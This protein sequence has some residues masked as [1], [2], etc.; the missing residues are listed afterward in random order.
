MKLALDPMEVTNHVID[1]R[2]HF[3]LDQ[4]GQEPSTKFIVDCLMEEY[5]EWGI[6]NE[7]WDEL[8]ALIDLLTF[9]CGFLAAKEHYK[10]EHIAD[11]FMHMDHTHW[12]NAGKNSINHFLFRHLE[13]ICE[14]ENALDELIPGIFG[15]NN[16]L[17]QKIPRLIENFEQ[18]GHSIC[19]IQL[20][21]VIYAIIHDRDF[22]LIFKD[23]FLEVHNANMKKEVGA[24]DKRGGFKADLIKP[25][26]WQPPNLRKFFPPS[27]D[28]TIE[29]T[30]A[31]VLK[32]RG[33]RYGEF[34]DNARITTSIMAIMESGATW[35]KQPSTNKEALRMIAHKIARVVS[36]DPF[37]EDN[38]VD[39]A[40]YAE[41]ARKEIVK[42]GRKSQI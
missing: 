11:L 41:L 34:I 29:D 30:V 33:S 23:A 31:S 42:C 16:S 27:L 12:K 36:G 26:G 32:D 35:L 10:Q 40:G 4:P 14:S 3:G 39:I 28:L 21:Y 38:F 9:A 19:L 15:D 24:N 6:A 7:K 2:K 8:D 22:G 13:E 25:E 37:H 17:F 1:M 5:G 18:N 20:I